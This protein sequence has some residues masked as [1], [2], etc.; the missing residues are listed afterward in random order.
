MSKIYIHQP[1]FLPSLNFFHRSKVSDF[2]VVL[3]DVQ[4]NRRGWTNRDLIKTQNGSE[5]ITVPV[6]YMP[7]KISLIKD[8][9][10]SYE[11]NWIDELTKKIE[12]NYSKSNNFLKVFRLLNLEFNKK[13]K[14]LIDLNLSLIKSIFLLFDIKTKIYF[15]SK[16]RSNRMKSEKILEICKM[17]KCDEYITGQGSKNYLDVKKF[18]KNKIK[19]NFFIKFKEKYKQLNGKFIEN[20][21]VI[22]YLFNCYNEVEKNKL[23]N[24]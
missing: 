20:L 22:D 5:K 4:F 12:H 23:F 18:E 11:T 16:L 1:D 13:H 24:E 21:S 3:D 9:Q 14:K 7:R 2:F 6:K 8:I 10:I 17:L 19:V 15:S